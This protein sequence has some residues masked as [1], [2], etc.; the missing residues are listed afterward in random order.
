MFIT[1]MI[2]K[3]S[4]FYFVDLCCKTEMLHGRSQVG[5]DSG[6]VPLCMYLYVYYFYLYVYL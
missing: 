6:H 2:M 4:R 3:W 1:F 5:S